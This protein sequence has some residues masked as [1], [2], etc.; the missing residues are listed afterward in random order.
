MIS[1]S[2]TPVLRDAEYFLLILWI[3]CWHEREWKLDS[4]SVILNLLW[5]SIPRHGLDSPA[6]GV[7]CIYLYDFYKM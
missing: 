1:F 6:L 2:P 7:F 5:Y 4:Y 3:L